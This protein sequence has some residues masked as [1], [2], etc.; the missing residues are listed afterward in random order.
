MLDRGLDFVFNRPVPRKVKTVARRSPQ[1][2]RAADT[3]EVLL[4]AT[5][6][7]LARRGFHKTT[8]NHIAQ[9]AGVSIGTLYHYFPTKEALVAAVV[10][11][12]WRGEVEAFARTA[13]AFADKP[14][15]EAI[16]DA[17]RALCEHVASKSE[18]YRSWYVEASQLGDLG[19]GLAMSGQ[20]T[21]FVRAALEA[22]GPQVRVRDVGFASDLV[23]KTSLAMIRT[24]ARD[25]EGALKDGTL[26][27]ELA[28]MIARYLLVDGSPP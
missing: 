24:G 23:V 21:A 22:A 13:P 10:E 11:R 16:H 7:E 2:K 3:V 12:L 1:Q 25:Y 19:A 18:V 6:I 28:D 5:E 15:R 26:A 20:A 27:R 9:A 4:D 14:L 8:T 17:L